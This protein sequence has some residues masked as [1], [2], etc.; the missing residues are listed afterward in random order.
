MIYFIK[1]EHSGRIKIGTTIRLSERLKAITKDA[2]EPLRILAV[3]DGSFPEEKSLHDR[4]SH[5][6]AFGEWFEP[7]DDL[8]GFIVET[9]REWD[10]SDEETTRE[11]KTVAVT[12][13]GSE[14]WK[15]WLER[16][17]KHCR[18]TVSAFIDTAA[19]E[20]AKSRGFKEEPPER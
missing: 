20:L 16:A 4:F 15:N 19:M 7:G 2:G 10:R 14:E 13:K 18:L 1:A 5:L 17:A 8:L 11:R 9:G 12:L 3:V 6:R